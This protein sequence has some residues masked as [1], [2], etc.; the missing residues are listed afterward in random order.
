M[1]KDAF[2]AML[3]SGTTSSTNITLTDR[4]IKR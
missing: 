3:A 4:Q 2:F 1:A